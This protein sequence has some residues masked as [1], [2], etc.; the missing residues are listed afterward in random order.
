MGGEVFHDNNSIRMF[1]LISSSTFIMV[2]VARAL[3]NNYKLLGTFLIFSEVRKVVSL[4]ELLQ[5]VKC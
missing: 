5:V 4:G 1:Q 3:L 2:K